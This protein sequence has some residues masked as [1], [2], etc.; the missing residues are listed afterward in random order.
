MSCRTEQCR[1][2]GCGGTTTRPLRQ[3]P[4]RSADNASFR[5][6]QPAYAHR[7]TER[8]EPENTKTAPKFRFCLN[9]VCGDGNIKE[10][11]PRRAS[12]ITIYHSVLT[13]FFFFPS[14]RSQ[15]ISYMIRIVHSIPVRLQRSTL[16][17]HVYRV[18][19]YR[20]HVPL[21]CLPICLIG[22]PIQENL[23]LTRTHPT[24]HYPQFSQ[25]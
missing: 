23:I 5:T 6:L 3:A 9:A 12:P 13:F 15:L 1:Q 14:K 25:P 18:H 11:I 20:V 21:A 22:F 16:H 19:V 17:V 8:L 2:R 4:T 10:R 24:N 7:K